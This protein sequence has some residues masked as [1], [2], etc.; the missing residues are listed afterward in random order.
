MTTARDILNSAFRLVTKASSD[1]PMSATEAADG[2]QV[3]NQLLTDLCNSA[4]LS[5][6]SDDLPTPL[7]HDAAIRYVLASM[8]STEFEAALAPMDM[9]RANQAESRLAAAYSDIPEVSFDAGLKD[10]TWLYSSD[11]DT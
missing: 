6:L 4:P 5:N 11:I 3:L 8:L 10:R 7:R 2:L 9:M 1:E